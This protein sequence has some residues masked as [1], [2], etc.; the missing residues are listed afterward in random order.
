MQDFFQAPLGLMVSHCLKDI[1]GLLF[2]PL[3]DQDDTSQDPELLFPHSSLRS[4]VIF[5]GEFLLSPFF[6]DL[7]TISCRGI[8]LPETFRP[9][10][11]Y[12]FSFKG[13][14]WHYSGMSSLGRGWATGYRG[15]EKKLNSP[16][17]LIMWWDSRMFGEMTYLLEFTIL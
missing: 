14:D 12:N 6:Y 1:A 15:C 3:H 16:I 17:R 10:W 2:R 13:R 4:I 7:N 8:L 9:N 11:F 5:L